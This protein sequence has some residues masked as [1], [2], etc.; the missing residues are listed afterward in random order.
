MN[1]ISDDRAWVALL[2]YQPGTGLGWRD[3]GMG[4]GKSEKKFLMNLILR[5]A[6][7]Q[8]LKIKRCCK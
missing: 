3:E 2:H 7:K 6:A 8:K 1:F 4:K 5:N